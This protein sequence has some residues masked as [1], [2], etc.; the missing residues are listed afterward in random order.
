MPHVVFLTAFE[1]HAPR[2]FEVHALDYLVKPIND[3]RFAAM[4][5]M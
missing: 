3:Q 5:N 4:M 2:A 1:E